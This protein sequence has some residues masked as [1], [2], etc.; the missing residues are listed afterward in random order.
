MTTSIGPAVLDSSLYIAELRV[1]R[2]ESVLQEL[3]R[4]AHGA[5]AVREPELLLETLGLREKLGTTALGK[6]VAVPNARSLAVPDPRLVVARAAKGIDWKAPDELPVQIVLLVLSPAEASI[7]AHHEFLG[8]AIGFARLQKNRQR[9]LDAAGF[10][11]VA[12]VLREVA[13]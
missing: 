1:K 2:K 13:P 7:D 4:C 12:A 3:V 11:E 8:R 5:G 6:G 10:A 9:L